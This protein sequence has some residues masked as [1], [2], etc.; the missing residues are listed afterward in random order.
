MKLMVIR[1]GGGREV[2]MLGQV[3]VSCQQEVIDYHLMCLAGSSLQE[4]TLG[5]FFNEREVLA[6]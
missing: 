4:E 3:K 2:L 6:F 1:E 5:N